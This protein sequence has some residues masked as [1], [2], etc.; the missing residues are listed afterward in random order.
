MINVLETIKVDINFKYDENINSLFFGYTSGYKMEIESGIHYLIH[1]PCIYMRKTVVEK[2]E[3]IKFKINSKIYAWKI[4]NLL[5][6]HEFEELKPYPA[7]KY[8]IFMK[9]HNNDKF[10]SYIRFDHENE[11]LIKVENII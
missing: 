11:S 10:C 7:C 4:L 5:G 3:I 2:P 9:K 6:F 8:T 1:Y